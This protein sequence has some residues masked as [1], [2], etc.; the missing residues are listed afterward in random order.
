MRCTNSPAC[1]GLVPPQHGVPSWLWTGLIPGADGAFYT[2]GA[3]GTNGG[4]SVMRFDPVTQTF[5][6]IEIMMGTG[7]TA[8]FRATG[9]GA[10]CDTG[11]TLGV[12]GKTFSAAMGGDGKIYVLPSIYRPGSQTNLAC[13]FVV[14]DT[15]LQT[16][17]ATLYVTYPDGQG[18]PFKEGKGAWRANWPTMFPA[19]STNGAIHMVPAWGTAVSLPFAS[20]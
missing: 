16:A 13:G 14:I 9:G 8:G 2:F 18:G 19:P 6:I 4:N 12:L 15:L 11:P 3:A 5:K 7:G 10:G 1:T 20:V 17:T